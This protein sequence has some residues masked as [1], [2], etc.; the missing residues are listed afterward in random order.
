MIQAQIP[1]NI[2]CNGVAPDATARDIDRGIE[3]R[4]TVSHALILGNNHT[5]FFFDMSHHKFIIKRKLTKITTGDTSYM[6]VI[7]QVK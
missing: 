3:I 5:I 4:L 2:H 6:S 7:L 1:V